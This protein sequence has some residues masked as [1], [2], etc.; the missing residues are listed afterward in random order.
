MVYSFFYLR[1][2]NNKLKSYEFN[3]HFIFSTIFS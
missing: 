3:G 2:I 1:F